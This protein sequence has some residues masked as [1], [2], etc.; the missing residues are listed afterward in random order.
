MEIVSGDALIIRDLNDDSIKKIYISSILGP[1]STN[2]QQIK[3]SL[4][5]IP[6]L[7]QAR[8]LLRKYS[9][10]KT[11]RVV[12]DYIQPAT[13][14]YPE[15]IC[16]TVYVDNINIGE[17]LISQGLAKVIRHQQDDEQRSSRYG[18]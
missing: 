13:N 4:H 9:I 1:R 7:F 18:R 10:G 14:N 16:C 15:K 17:V 6:Y 2:L 8:E 5:D 12:I 3:R 11:V